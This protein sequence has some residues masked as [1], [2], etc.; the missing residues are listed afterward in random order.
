M[1]KEDFSDV[2][3]YTT[4]VDDDTVY[5]DKNALHVH[6]AYNFMT[7]DGRYV[8]A[9][10]DNGSAIDIHGTFI[11]GDYDN[12]DIRLSGALLNGEPVLLIGNPELAEVTHEGQAL[13]NFSVIN[14]QGEIRNYTLRDSNPAITGDVFS[15]KRVSP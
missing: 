5:V 3:L 7:A 12:D 15:L 10:F 2:F 13:Y 9:F 14:A 6:Q 11:I 4:I 1:K 8:D